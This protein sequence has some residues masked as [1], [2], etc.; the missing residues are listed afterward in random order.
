MLRHFRE[1]RPLAKGEHERAVERRSLGR[2]RPAG[3]VSI[4][5]AGD[6]SDLEPRPRGRVY[7][8]LGRVLDPSPSFAPPGVE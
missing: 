4:A 1:S 6:D 3:L 7:D 5:H 2:P 8:W